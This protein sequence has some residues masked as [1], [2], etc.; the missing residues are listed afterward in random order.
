[1][2][3]S[4]GLAS[5]EMPNTSLSKDSALRSR[6]RELFSLESLLPPGEVAR[7][8]VGEAED[9]GRDEEVLEG[10][11]WAVGLADNEGMGRGICKGFGRTNVSTF[12]EFLGETM[13]LI[14]PLLVALRM[15]GREE[16]GEAAEGDGWKMLITASCS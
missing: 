4:A 16:L 9:P 6:L 11:D 1:M 14:E 13:P 3:V 7:M 10:D 5:E 12:E 15:G 8:G 2:G